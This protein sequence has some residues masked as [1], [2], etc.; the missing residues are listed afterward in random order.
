MNRQNMVNF[1]K[2]SGVSTMETP[3][4]AMFFAERAGQVYFVDANKADTSGDGKS[5]ATAFKSLTTA[6]AA[7]HANIALTSLR[8]WA[9]R[10]TIY[11]K[12]DSMDEDLTKLAQ[13]TDIIGVG[14]CNQHPRPRIKGTHVIEAQTVADYMGCR[15]FNIEFLASTAGIIMTIPAN[16]NGVVFDSTCVFNGNSIATHGLLFTS[17]HDSEV[18][19]CRFINGFTTA[20]IKVAAGAITNFMV[21]KCLIQGQG[22]GIEFLPT[23]TQAVECWAIDNVIRTTGMPIDSASDTAFSSLGCVGNRMITAIDASTPTNGYDFALSAAADNL[24]TGSQGTDQIP[25]ETE[26]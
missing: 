25:Y 5:W 19:G 21:Q 13:K 22:I 24:L 20:C 1:L 15:F 17:S 7:S 26:S 11:L 9:G 3:L 12:G 23:T 4:E 2:A 18:N 8:N 14:S 10:N 6:L 16:Q